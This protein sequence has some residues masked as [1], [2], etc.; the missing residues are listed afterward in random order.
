M[1]CTTYN[2]RFTCCTDIYEKVGDNVNALSAKLGERT[3]KRQAYFTSLLSELYRILQQ[4]EE[5][6]E[7]KQEIAAKTM[8][9]LKN[10]TSDE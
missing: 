4:K 9:L 7:Q 2:W 3:Q 6:C 1:N 10:I 8:N 5:L